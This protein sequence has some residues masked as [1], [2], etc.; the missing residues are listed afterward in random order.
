MK[1]RRLSLRTKITL[2]I[3]ISS[4]LCLGIFGF[5]C[6]QRVS[7]ELIEQIRAEALHIAEIA[8]SEI[9]GDSYATISDYD[10]DAFVEVYD[11]LIKYRESSVV[12]YIYTMRQTGPQKSVFVVDTDPD[13]PGEIDEEYDWLEVFDTV[14][15]GTPAWDE[16]LTV[17]EWGVF[18]SGYAPIFD[19]NNKVVGLVGCDV[20]LNEMNRDVAV[21]GGL[22]ITLVAIFSI[23]LILLAGIIGFKLGRNLKALYLKV[24]EINSGDA[25]LTKQVT[26][27]SGDELETIA[28]EVNTFISH[29]REQMV[30]AAGTSEIVAENSEAMESLV[31]ECRGSLSGIA[32]DLLRLSESM[33]DTSSD[34]SAILDGINKSSDIVERA[35]ENSNRK[36]DDANRISSEAGEME[37]KIAQKSQNTTAMVDSLKER[38]EEAA[39]KC[40]AV[41]EIEELADKILKVSS[42]TKMLSL[43]ASIEA[44]RAGEAGRG[45]SI[46]AG[47][48]QDLSSQIT[49]L[50]ENIRETNEQVI[51][52]V[53]GLIDNVKET[54]GFL[55]DEVL[56]DYREFSKMGADY[57]TNMSDMSNALKEINEN[58]AKVDGS[59][60][61]IRERADSINSVITES[62]EKIE[63]VAKGSA[64]LEGNMNDLTEKAVKNNDEAKNLNDNISEYK[65]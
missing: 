33:K 16:D 58:L 30:G 53:E 61:M 55:N 64:V 57:S 51:V 7:K 5:V 63:S 29:I 9:D 1:T 41:H 50:V 65:L 19:S 17:D 4:V 39:L 34:T 23:V 46:I 48:V 3:A 8:A 35:Y 12:E 18:I 31:E 52:S 32:S 27:N 28:G 59:M 25:D 14:Y 38:L 24:H 54:T 44:A 43:N 37:R 15:G 49:E 22:V 10:D 40:Q 47:D 21:V 42:T 2:I 45:F 26:I 13:E 36:A 11:G 20:S 56:P 60:N 6:Y 62:S